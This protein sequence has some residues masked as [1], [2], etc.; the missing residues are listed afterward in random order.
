MRP[1]AEAIA[2]L[3]VVVGLIALVIFIGVEAALIWTAWRYRASKLP[4]PAPQLYGHRT[5]EIAWTAA[6]ILVLAVV[7]ALMFNTMSEIGFS[8]PGAGAASL[9]VQATG[10]QWWWQFTYTRPGGDVVVSNELHIPV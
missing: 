5:L 4:G 3:A 1:P 7:G 2:G 10:H 9:K 6:P 8:T